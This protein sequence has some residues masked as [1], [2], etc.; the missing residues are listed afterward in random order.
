MTPLA[1]PVP[2]SPQ[3]PYTYVGLGLAGIGALLLLI[4]HVVL[5]N[6]RSR[7]A[8]LTSAA[9]GLVIGLGG[10]I[11][12][13][14]SHHMALPL[15]VNLDKS[16]ADPPP[17]LEEILAY[18][19]RAEV[20][21]AICEDVGIPNLWER[22]ARLELLDT[23]RKIIVAGEWISHSMYDG[24]WYSR[25]IVDPIERYALLGVAEILENRPDPDRAGA[26][27]YLHN[28][29]YP[30]GGK[31][32]KRFEEMRSRAFQRLLDA[33]GDPDV[34]REMLKLAEPTAR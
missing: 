7:R 14:N 20:R 18:L 19:N 10:G 34:K 12:A 29:A 21:A 8:S 28:A 32:L 23:E 4:S 27:L 11:L 1:L 16:R 17:R 9:I 25:N 15:S 26:A 2:L 5:W 30:R 31:N 3:T 6:R 24:H 33:Q 13:W 22:Y